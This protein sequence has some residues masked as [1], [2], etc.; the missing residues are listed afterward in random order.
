MDPSASLCLIYDSLRQAPPEVVTGD[1]WYDSLPQKLTPNYIQ[2]D[3]RSAP[4]SI[5]CDAYRCGILKRVKDAFNVPGFNEARDA[6][7]PFERIGNSIFM[8]RSGVKL[9]NIDAVHH[10]SGEIFTFD[11]KKSNKPW[12]F[13]DITAGPGGWTQYLQYRF[14]NSQGYGMTLRTV[15]WN[16]KLLDMTRFT[17]FYGSDNTGDLYTNAEQFIEFVLSQQYAGVSLVTADGG[18]DI[19]NPTDKN[20]W[21]Q[22]EWLSSR[23]LLV[24]SLIGIGCTMIGGNFVVKVFDT[25]T[26]IS[27]QIIFILSQCFQRILIWKPVSSGPANAEQYLICMSRKSLVQDMYQFLAGAARTYQDNIYLTSLFSEGLP[28]DFTTWLTNSSNR[29]VDNQLQAAQNILLYLKGTPPTI[30][31]YNLAKFLTIWNLPD[32]PINS[33]NS[34]LYL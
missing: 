15:D 24:Q 8:N 18:F 33:K 12:T 29:S 4:E 27:A 31:E 32:T 14:P 6:M 13:C 19:E 2:V 20:L 9:A 16:T 17:P 21:H 26:E 10:V 11:T 22:Q 1:D 30:P 25:T 7:N 34:S 23:L 5:Y 3:K 28:E